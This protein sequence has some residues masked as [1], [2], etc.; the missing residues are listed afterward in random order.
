MALECVESI[1]HVTVIVSYPFNVMIPFG[2]TDDPK[3][4]NFV[5]RLTCDVMDTLES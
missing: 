2:L 3:L 4:A 1:L 5:F